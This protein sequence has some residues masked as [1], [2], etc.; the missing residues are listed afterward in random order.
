M[1][2][3]NA[4]AAHQKHLAV[5][6]DADNAPAAIVEGLSMEIHINGNRKGLHRSHSLI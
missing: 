2:S 1:A 5:L 4:P 3:K 6:I